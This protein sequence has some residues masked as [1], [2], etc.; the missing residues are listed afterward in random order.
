[1]SFSSSFSI[2]GSRR[3]SAN[4]MIVKLSSSLIFENSGS[5]YYES[6]IRTCKLNNYLI[7]FEL[8]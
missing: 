6:K 3:S 8:G 2:G 5:A 1:M 7:H 4:I